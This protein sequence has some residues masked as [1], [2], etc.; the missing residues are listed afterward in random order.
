M[1][2]HNVSDT[3]TNKGLGSMGKAQD[4]EPAGGHKQQTTTNG[5]QQTVNDG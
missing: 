1:Y 4:K 2:T 5:E 3:D